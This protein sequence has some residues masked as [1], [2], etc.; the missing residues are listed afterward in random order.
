MAH[1]IEMTGGMFVAVVLAAVV[2]SAGVAVAATQLS[3]PQT[4]DA[5]ASDRAVVKQLQALR[6][7]FRAQPRS[8]RAVVK[9]LQAFRKE[10]RQQLGNPANG[11]VKDKLERLCFAEGGQYS[12]VGCQP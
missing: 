5:A 10:F 6:K 1:P 4:A 9:Q 3:Q 12:E 2:L 8:D 7:E 11:D